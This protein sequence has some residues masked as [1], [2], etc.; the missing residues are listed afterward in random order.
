LAPSSITRGKL[1]RLSAPRVRVEGA[2]TF[3]NRRLDGRLSARSSALAIE[4]TGIADLG[5]S[6]WRNLRIRARLLRPA[7]L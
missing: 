7:A 6:A 5:E 2:G 1:Q 4:A 3:V